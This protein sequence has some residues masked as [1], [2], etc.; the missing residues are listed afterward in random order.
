[1]SI[2]KGRL[3][4]FQTAFLLQSKERKQESFQQEKNK[5]ESYLII[6]KKYEK[7]YNSWI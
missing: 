7:E 1:M 4:S 2:K 6:R 3:K 5:V